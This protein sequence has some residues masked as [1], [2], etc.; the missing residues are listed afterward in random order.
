M[1]VERP[2]ALAPHAVIRLGRGGRRLPR[3]L[4][5][6]GGA[7]PSSLFSMAFAG[8]RD[9]ALGLDHAYDPSEFRLEYRARRERHNGRWE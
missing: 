8:R 7:A 4:P 3:L 5:Q 1:S 2:T 6:P 9:Y